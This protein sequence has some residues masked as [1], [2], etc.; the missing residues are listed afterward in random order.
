[1][2]SLVSLAAF[3]ALAFA[4][5]SMAA[6]AAPTTSATPTTS[7]APAK[8]AKN[9]KSPID[10]TSDHAEQHSDCTGIWSGSAEALQDNSRLRS[11]TMIAHLEIKKD[12]KPAAPVGGGAVA[13]GSEGNCGDVISLE[14]IGNVYFV[15]ATGR[16]VHGDHGYYD[17]ASTTITI[18]GD[19]TAVD[20][21]NVMRGTK[22]V[23][24]TDTGEGHMEGAAQGPGAKDR[25]RGVFYP[26][27]AT[28]DASADGTAA[29][30]TSDTCAKPK[31]K[32]TTQ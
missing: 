25:P 9:Q 30:T 7:A 18:T 29:G 12:V 23:Y 8:P 15:S 19:V 11:D 3:V 4:T 32:K 1:M 2:K 21:Q 16:K 14:A 20:G 10:I 17:M 6:P 28:P 13:S 22:M 5:S 26:K 27:D 31:K 24:N